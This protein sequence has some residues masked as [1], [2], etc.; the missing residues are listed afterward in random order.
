MSS[1]DEIFTQISFFNTEIKLRQFIQKT[2]S[3]YIY[4]ANKKSRHPNEC[5]QMPLTGL[6]PVRTFGSRD[7]KFFS[8]LG[9]S[10]QFKAIHGSLCPRK[11]RNFEHFMT[12][13][14]LSTVIKPKSKKSKIRSI[15]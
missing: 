14:S 9:N 15:W 5:L 2:N 1:A 7:F 8:Q 13:T 3:G 11:R 6:E 12:I 10:W 4:Y